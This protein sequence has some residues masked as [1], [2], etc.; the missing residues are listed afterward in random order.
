MARQ[1]TGQECYVY[2]LRSKSKN[3]ITP[4]PKFNQVFND[5][6]SEGW[7]QFS[8]YIVVSRKMYELQRR[9]EIYLYHVLVLSYTVHGE[10]NI[11]GCIQKFPD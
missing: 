11:R 8:M 2:D 1:Y 9:R 7:L 3:K 5:P 10:D 6:P 4:C